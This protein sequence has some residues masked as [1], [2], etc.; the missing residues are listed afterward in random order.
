VDFVVLI[1]FFSADPNRVCEPS[2][3]SAAPNRSHVGKELEAGGAPTRR[4]GWRAPGGDGEEGRRLD[5]E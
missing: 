2:E 1:S 5:G 3:P 4:E